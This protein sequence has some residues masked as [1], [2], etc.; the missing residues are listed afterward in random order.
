MT[1][2]VGFW[3]NRDPIGEQGGL[4]LYAYVRNNPINLF[5]P[6]GLT[7][8]AALAAAIANQEN[9]IYGAIQSMMGINQ[10]FNSAENMQ[11]TALGGDFA[12]AALGGGG[13]AG[14]LGEFN[15]VC[16]LKTSI[17]AWRSDFRDC[18]WTNWRKSH[19]RPAQCWRLGTQWR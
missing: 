15:E 3:P 1:R 14:E 19:D 13:A 9:N 8:C 4:N 17:Y 10:M 12:Y 7:D 6:F 16:S 5:D 18:L 2:W 11:I